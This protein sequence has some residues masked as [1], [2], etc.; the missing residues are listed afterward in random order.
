MLRE[1]KTL[2]GCINSEKETNAETLS[3]DQ[4]SKNGE[5]RMTA[6]Q[7]ALSTVVLTL[8]TCGVLFIVF[9]F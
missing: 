1:R 7:L 6:F 5:N 2:Y 3:F 8:I 9:D 4:E